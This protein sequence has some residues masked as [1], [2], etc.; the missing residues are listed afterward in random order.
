MEQRHERWTREA[1]E[2]LDRRTGA[3][4][5]RYEKLRSELVFKRDGPQR[6][7]GG[8]LVARR[9]AD[10]IKVGRVKGHVGAGVTAGSAIDTAPVPQAMGRIQDV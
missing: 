7:R 9:V 6:R 2:D 8:G 4:Y 3:F 5:E 10:G 1:D